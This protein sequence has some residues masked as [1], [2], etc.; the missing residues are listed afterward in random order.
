MGYIRH[1]AVIVLVA[2]EE[3]A[4]L[5]AFLKSLDE[6]DRLMFA[7]P[8]HGANGY[9]SFFMAPDGSK[10]GWDTSNHFDCIRQRFIETAE[11]RCASA[12]VVAIQFG[13]DNRQTRIVFTTDYQDNER[14]GYY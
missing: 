9:V 1:D 5:L 14:E 13:G 12:S 4:P 2:Q 6:K 10:E 8:I 11:S 7:G 3:T